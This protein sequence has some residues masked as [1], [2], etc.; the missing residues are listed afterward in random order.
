MTE[1][2]NEVDFFFLGGGLICVVPTLVYIV[3]PGGLST[4]DIITLTRSLSLQLLG[5]NSPVW[6]SHSAGVTGV[7]HLCPTFYAGPGN[8]K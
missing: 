4:S 7:T 3:Q 8:S 2:D 1:T 6:V 5:G